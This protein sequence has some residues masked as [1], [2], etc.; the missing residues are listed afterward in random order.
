MAKLLGQMEGNSTGLAIME[1]DNCT[2]ENRQLYVFYSSVMIVEFI[3]GLP[4]NL[5]VLYLFIFKLKFW[6]S[7]SNTIF[8]FNLVLADILLLICLPVKAYHFQIGVR[9]SND[10]FVCKGMLFMLFLN[11][12]ASIAFLTVISVDRYFSVV[13]PRK[14]NFL[15]VL[16]RSPQVSV[17]IWALLLPLTIPTMHK[18]FECCNSYG[19]EDDHFTDTLREIV[20]F[21]QILI[22]FFVLVFC[23][24]QVIQRLKRKTVGDRT[25][26]R[27][28][29][30]L[31]TS[32]VLVFSICF[33]PCTI[34]R[35][36]LLIFR[37]QEMHNK[38]DIAVQVHDG[39]MVFSY[40]D[41]LLDPLVYCFCSARFKELY[42]SNIFP[43]LLPKKKPNL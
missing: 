9:R 25:K 24:V 36:I 34:S 30:F 19:R 35:M 16:K 28:A 20:F 41:C 3:V 12:G 42:I 33:L 32:V 7:N 2:T 1:E 8:L 17:L 21:T 11:R 43:F 38:E 13:H 29:V 40:L 23:T 14:K 18:S 10:E 4:L 6:K 39:L 37:V 15:K 22:P 5:T 27:R 31:V 26:L